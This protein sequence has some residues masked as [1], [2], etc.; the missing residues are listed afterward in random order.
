M[1]NFSDYIH[2]FSYNIDASHLDIKADDIVIYLPENIEEIKN[3]IKYAIDNNRNIILRGS[4]TNLVGS[5]LPSNHSCVI[6]FSKMNHILGLKE[7]SVEVEPG[8]ILDDLNIYLGKNSLYFPVV[9]GSHVA[10]QIGSTVATNAAGMRAIK[11]GKMERWINSIDVIVVNKNKEIEELHLEKPEISDFLNSEGILGIITKINL[12]VIKKPELVTLDFIEFE[13]IEDLIKK[14]QELANKKDE[15]N[16]SAIEFIDKMVGKY[17]GLSDN[18]HLIV[19][20]END[21][22]EIKDINK[23]NEIWSIRDNCYPIVVRQGYE[24]IED[25]QVDLANIS[26]LIIWLEE[27]NIPTFGHIGIGIL[28]PHYKIEQKELSQEMYKIVEKLHGNVSGEH[29][30]G[31]KKKILI[32]DNYRNKYKELKEKYDPNGIFGA[33]SII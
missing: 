15:L 23:I 1:K 19:E 16:I 28:H 22:G 29:G 30:I 18:Y 21:H 12:E 26:E 17:Q 10:A 7:N 5:C 4:G 20:Y 6:D 24:L 11:Y 3:A 8:V 31:I 33:G 32:D 14:A 9:P 2:Q 27:H 25:P 13:K